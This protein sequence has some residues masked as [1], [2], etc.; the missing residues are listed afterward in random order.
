MRDAGPFSQSIYG[1]PPHGRYARRDASGG[2][3]PCPMWITEVN[4]N[5]DLM[6]PGIGHAAALWVKT[7]AYLRYYTFYPAKGVERVHTYNIGGNETGFGF[8]SDA[9]MSWAAG[10]HTAL[11]A[12]VSAYET[13]AQRALT[14]LYDA[15]LA[16]AD[17]SAASPWNLTLAHW[18]ISSGHEVPVFAAG[19]G[20]LA[21]PDLTARDMFVFLPLSVNST[22]ACVLFYVMH[23]NIFLDPAPIPF[24]LSIAG[25]PAPPRNVSCHTFDPTSMAAARVICTM[26]SS[27]Q[28][29]VSVTATDY[30]RALFVDWAP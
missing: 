5:P 21:F 3:L 7:K 1:G 23:P 15:L 19:N 29:T 20:S 30:P 25:L 6:Q 24:D 10:N 12:N 2:V 27:Q 18:N 16:G 17:T 9:F 26:A 11:P 28:L 13:P 4:V 14:A 8:L 22:R